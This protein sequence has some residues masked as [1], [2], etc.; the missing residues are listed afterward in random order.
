[1]LGLLSE[2]VDAAPAGTPLTAIAAAGGLE[3]VYEGDELPGES[4]LAL[5]EAIARLHGGDL[6][7]AAD[8]ISVVVTLVLA[9]EPVA[10]RSAA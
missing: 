4:S 9:A 1:V 8:G 10:I 5:A 3:L 7:V 6:T 2:A